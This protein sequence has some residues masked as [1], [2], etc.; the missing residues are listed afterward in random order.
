MHL[1]HVRLS[2]AASEACAGAPGRR[3]HVREHQWRFSPSPSS[4]HSMLVSIL[5]STGRCDTVFEYPLPRV[6]A[7]AR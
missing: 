7:D 1:N 2:Q 3:T 5:F 6:E 4:S